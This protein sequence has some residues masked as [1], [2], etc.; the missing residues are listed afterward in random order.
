MDGRSAIVE[1]KEDFVLYW[2]R[3]A[4]RAH[5]NPALD[6]A[7]LLAAQCELPLLVYHGLSDSYRFAS[8]RHHTFI[9]EGAADVQRRFFEAGIS[10]AFHLATRN[11]RE[12]RL[13]SLARKAALV[14]TEEMPVDPARRYLK[15]LLSI[16]RAPVF[17]VDTACV[18]PMRLVLEPYT[19]AFQYREATR[20]LYAERTENDWPELEIKTQPF[21]LEQLPFAAVD[22]EHTSI[23]ELVAACDIDHSIGS[24][25]GTRGGTSAGYARWNEFR[26]SRLSRYARARNNALEDGVS[27]MSAY[28][29]YGMVSPMR[30]AR[31]A[32]AEGTKGAEKYLDEL[33]IWRE[34]AY[35]FCFHR[36][37]HDQLSAVPDWARK[38]LQRHATD[39]REKIY[40]WEQLSRASTDDSLWNA[41]QRS[42]LRN[43]ELHNNVRM[44]WG[45]AILNW[46][47]TP[48]EALEMIVDLNNR[49]A[50]DGRDPA[51]Y[52]GILWCLGQFDRPFKPELPVIGTVR[53][54][55]LSIHA[56][57]LDP[58]AFDEKVSSVK[59]RSAQKVGIVGAG[60]SGLIAAR[61]LAD[62]GFSVEVFEKSRGVGGRMS[63]RRA[64]DRLR[65][66]H[67]AQ[68]FTVRDERFEKYVQSWTEQGVVARWPDP[69]VGSEQR[70]VVLKNGA[71][72][73]ESSPL[74]RFVGTPAMNSIC[75]HLARDAD[76]HFNT[77]IGRVEPDDERIRL[78]DETGK[79]WGTFD[80][81]VVSSPAEQAAAMLESYPGLA[82]VV[83]AVEMNPCL[84][85]MV[86]F[87]EPVTDE[88][89]GA[90]LHDSFLSWVARNGT[91]PGRDRIPES[92]IIHAGNQWSHEHFDADPEWIAQEMLREFHRVSGTAIQ[93]P[94]HLVSHRWKYAIPPQP[95]K[96]GCFFDADAGIAVCGDWAS[97]ARVE[98]AFLSGM[99]ASGRILTQLRR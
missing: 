2:M 48:A 79:S 77:R 9:L 30:I 91:K 39:E 49:Y 89:V 53:P 98:G 10:Y 16:C 80:S 33:L 22:F 7:R 37:D 28:L 6:V 83:G 55:P 25:P 5:E 81:V 82:R 3:N 50:L 88:W 68:Y 64:H 57:R 51:S 11:D 38:T 94:E 47:R 42:L 95:E 36:E 67:G 35:A 72:E 31:E 32:S 40:T 1:D 63:T 46:T 65:F 26:N 44:T 54:R 69:A 99:A 13:K 27:R 12:P 66:D 90:F 71:I 84:A 87:E 24:V 58:M 96:T 43:G 85:T 8:D 4:V 97:G 21:D 34:L 61:T 60:L 14:V 56:K 93:K 75:K 62:Q 20:E 74:P 73:S 23:Q 86:A 52:G 78:C 92:L 59:K 45:K 18:V 15:S 41:A 76:I 19:R 17:C 29:H 70:I